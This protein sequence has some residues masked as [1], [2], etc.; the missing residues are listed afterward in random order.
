MLR[1]DL[2]VPFAER[3]AARQLG[4]CWDPGRRVWFVP[5]DRDAT[6]LARWLPLADGVNIRAS[7]YFIAS[8]TLRCWRCRGTSPVCGFAL[9][10]GH[11]TLYVDDDT[12]R[13][14]WETAEEPT[15]LC[16]LDYLDAAVVARITAR[17]AVYRYGFRRQTQSFYWVNFCA[18]CN[19]KLGDYET[20]CEPGIGFMPL[21]REQATQVSLG[22]VD[23]P[24][25]AR[26]NGWSFGVELFEYMT[27]R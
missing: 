7:G 5:E 18:H 13:E 2:A 21:T 24:F 20:F 23:E 8:T 22:W 3:D 9:A 17:S 11:E 16:Y 6:P 12:G 25:A 15:L 14:F 4:A 26:A 27:R 10:A 1:I 19:T